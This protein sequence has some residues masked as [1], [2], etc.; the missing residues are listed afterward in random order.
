MKGADIGGRDRGF[1][2]IKT[3]DESCLKRSQTLQKVTEVQKIKYIIS[4]IFV[5]YF[6]NKKSL[7]RR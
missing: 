7:L 4:E 6:S 1:I 5:N 3:I 2:F